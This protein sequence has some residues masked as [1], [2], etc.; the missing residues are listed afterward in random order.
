MVT[1]GGVV[2]SV[3]VIAAVPTEPDAAVAVAVTMF[4]PSAS[5]S[6]M[7][8]LPFA[9]GVAMELIVSVAVGSSMVP[10]TVVGLILR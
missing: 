2:S 8:K 6:G 7:L 9:T 10:V 4:G 5:G 3:T 1:R